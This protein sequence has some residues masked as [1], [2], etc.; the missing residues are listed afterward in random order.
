[1]NS[2][3]KLLIVNNLYKSYYSLKEETE[4]LDDISFDVNKNDFI[5]IVGPSGCG[6]SSILNI[7]ANFDK[8]YFGKVIK[9]DNI[10][11]GYMFQQ[12]ALFPYLTIYENAILGLKIEKNLN[13]NSIKYVL[14]LLKKYN[15]L[16]FKDKYPN[17]LSG[18]MKQRLALIRTLATKPDILLLDEPY[19]A[20]DYQ[21]RLLVCN[22]VYKII[23]EENITAI[24]VTH[25]IEEA[26]S[27]CNKIIV[28]SKRP[29]HIKNIYNINVSNR[30][31]PISNRKNSEFIKYYD[32]IWKDIDI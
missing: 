30:S 13:T 11:I 22:D 23:K 19:S 7:I 20:L 9:K 26:V 2:T 17:E 1:M 3:N 15:L 4:V 5:A 25:D 16:D 32:I 27:M 29:S 12:D 24:I 10:K 31:D 14:N 6:K 28:L 21:T 8:N 18:G